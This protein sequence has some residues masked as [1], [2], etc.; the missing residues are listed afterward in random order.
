MGNTLVENEPIV[1]GTNVGL[2][3]EVE[4]KTNNS[5]E[6]ALAVE[7]VGRKTSSV[8]NEATVLEK[9]GDGVGNAPVV[10]VSIGVEI[11]SGDGDT[12]TSMEL[13][14][15]TCTM[16]EV[17][18]TNVSVGLGVGESNWDKVDGTDVGS[19]PGDVR[20]TATTV[21]CV[22]TPNIEVEGD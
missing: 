8:D 6:N 16:L 21:A 3:S 11:T 22:S 19:G 12:V 18:K 14:L 13:S 5:E 7:T 15:T 17:G 10:A 9:E 4:G 1:V 2:T 20:V